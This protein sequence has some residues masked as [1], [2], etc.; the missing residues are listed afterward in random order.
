MIR[1]DFKCQC[2]AVWTP[3]DFDFA[4]RWAAHAACHFTDDQLRAEC[5]R[6]GIDTM[7]P[8]MTK[9]WANDRDAYIRRADEAERRCSEWVESLK[10]MRNQRDEWKRRAEAAE[11]L[12]NAMPCSCEKCEATFHRRS[13]IALARREPR[14]LAA[15][16]AESGPGIASK[17]PPC[18][19]G[20]WVLDE[21]LLCGDER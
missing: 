4:E 10:D 15:L 3:S 1:G 14:P 19:D 8:E 16:S 5:E 12:A 2:G 17:P 21:D 7:T 18:T 9:A 20:H 11:A 6:R 13:A